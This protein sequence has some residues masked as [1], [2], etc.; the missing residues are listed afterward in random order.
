MNIKSKQITRLILTLSVLWVTF[1][2]HY[3][4]THGLIAFLGVVSI[5]LVCYFSVKMRVLN[6]QGHPLYFP[7]IQFSHYWMWLVVEILKAN[8][9]VTK[10]VIS[11]T[12]S[13]KP[14]LKAIPSSQKTEVGKVIFANSITLTPGTVAIN[15]TVNN[16]ILVH[17]LHAHELDD[18]EGGQM[19]RRVSLLEPSMVSGM[20]CEIPSPSNVVESDKAG[21][22]K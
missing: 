22:S 1:S 20:T 16:D 19:D 10:S 17:A 7:F 8:I 5:L 12:L 14:L 21:E 15:I 4:F 6:H 9:I 13:I 18:L 11:P 2:G 3:T